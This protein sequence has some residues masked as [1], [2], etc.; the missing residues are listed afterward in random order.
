MGNIRFMQ[1]SAYKVQRMTH[2]KVLRMLNESDAVVDS[3]DVKIKV[4]HHTD[5]Q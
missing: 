2:L 1:T 5:D 3:S 4:H